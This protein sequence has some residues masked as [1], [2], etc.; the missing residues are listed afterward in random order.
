MGPSGAGKFMN[1]KN[2]RGKGQNGHQSV[3]VCVSFS[4][5]TG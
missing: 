2:G 3:N 4:L 1:F 5:L